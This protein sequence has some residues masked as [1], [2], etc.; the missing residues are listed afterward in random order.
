MLFS[1]SFKKI[2]FLSI[3]GIIEFMESDSFKRASIIA[4][5]HEK[6]LRMDLSTLK[7]VEEF[8][9][10]LK[11]SPHISMSAKGEGRLIG[12]EKRIYKRVSA[13]VPISYKIVGTEVEPRM[14]RS[15]DLSAGGLKLVLFTEE[16]IWVGFLLDV[17]VYLPGKI[18][19]ISAQAKV[20]W[21][22]DYQEELRKGYEVGVE[23]IDIL[24]EEKI[25]IAK[26]VHSELKRK[27]VLERKS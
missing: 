2:D 8:V 12:Q 4:N 9:E 11:P 3:V 17:E 19:P 15:K 20:V 13:N 25:E 23:F 6:L 1:F 5:V 21:V 7:K 16:K 14:T 24:K 10:N 27:E 22:R 18:H 26:F